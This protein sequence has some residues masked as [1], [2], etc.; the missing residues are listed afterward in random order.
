MQDIY[1]EDKQFE[2]K[3]AL[4][5]FLKRIFSYSLRYKKWFYG[6]LFS[7]LVVGISDAIWPI[8]W[9]HFLDNVIIPT[10]DQYQQFKQSGTPFTIDKSGL[11][12]YFFYFFGNGVIQVIGVFGFVILA[13]KIQ[14]YVLYDLRDE[15]FRKLQS[16]S[17]SFYDKSALGWLLSRLTSDSD[18]VSELISWGFLDCLWGVTMIFA[19]LGMMF[20]YDWRLAMIVLLS[21]PIL[22][23]ASIK[24]RMLILKYSRQSRKINSEITAS[25]TEHINGVEVNKITAQETRI[26]NDFNGLSDN[27]RKST[28]KASF[29]TA[30]YMPIV[31]FIGSITA[32]FIINVGGRMAIAMPAGITVGILV[33]FFG[34]ATR[35]F[36]P[37]MDI[38]RFY[39]LAQ[40]SLSAG[41]RIF[42]L[43]DENIEIKDADHSS[44]FDTIKGE[45]KFENVDFAYVKDKPVLKNMNLH[46]KP[47]QSVALVG[48]TG[49][50]KTTISNLVGRFY[51]P[52]A[53]KILID[54]F[55]YQNKT[56]KSLRKQMGIVLQTPHLFKGSVQ[57]N[58]VYG[59]Q[60]ATQAEI[61]EALSMAGATQFVKRLAEEVGENGDNLSLGEKQLISFA[62]AILANPSILIMDEATSSVDTQTEM[63]IQK[64][65]DKLISGR[66]AIIIAHRLSTIKNCDRILVIS[67]GQIIEDGSHNELMKAKGNYHNLYTK[68]IRNK[69]M[70]EMA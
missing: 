68:Q 49:E 58:I 46:I 28:F 69:P 52:T 27:M 26:S 50:G 10:V 21:L 53:G 11:W 17:Y 47:G 56:L 32:I 7:V 37:I 1:L 15:M 54:G 64:G 30:L 33:A 9:M 19:C 42:G 51:Q 41:E 12:R 6:F 4:W 61:E 59:K 43:I 45:I 39:A 65:V 14:E 35:I 57:E 40:N 34:Y 8:I 62:R 38:T 67:K 13:G 48:A 70:V 36:E 25:F 5:P 22:F 24:L 29:Y 31:I 55:N 20:Y 23:V 16:L 18:R 66:T 3:G 60:D 2:G 44:D 63:Q